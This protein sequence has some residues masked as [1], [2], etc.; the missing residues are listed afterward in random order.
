MFKTF[1]YN[2]LLGL[3]LVPIPGFAM[4]GD[5]GPEVPKATCRPFGLKL[6]AV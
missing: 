3:E 4:W 6:T 2:F 5:A 1:E